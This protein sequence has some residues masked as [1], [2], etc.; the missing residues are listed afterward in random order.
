[1][2]LKTREQC[3]TGLKVAEANDALFPEF[4]N[5]LTQELRSLLEA[6]TPRR[7]TPAEVSQP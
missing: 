2:T 3:L 5:W 7:P 6:H 4:A 1:M